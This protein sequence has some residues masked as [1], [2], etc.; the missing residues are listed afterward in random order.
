M[1]NRSIIQGFLAAAFLVV[2][3]FAGVLLSPGDFIIAIDADGP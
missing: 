3:S 1:V 2:P